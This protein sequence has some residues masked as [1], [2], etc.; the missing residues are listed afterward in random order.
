MKEELEKMEIDNS[1]MDDIL[2]TNPESVLDKVQE[3]FEPN[4]NEQRIIAELSSGNYDNLVKVLSLLNKEGNTDSICIKDSTVNQASNNCIILA[5][6]SSVLKNK[7]GEPVNLD[8]LNPK[9][10]LKLLEQFRSQD[11]IFIIDDP[12]NQRFI[13]TN[14]EV[15]LFLPKQDT[16]EDSKEI[17]IFDTDNAEGICETKID[18]DMRKIIKNLS[19]DQERIDLLIQDNELKAI[20]IPE[21]AIY[22]F[23]EFKKDPKAQN[24]DETNADISLRCSNF[25]PVEADNYEFFIMKSGEDNYVAVTDCKVGGVIAVRVQ[26]VLEMATGGN[27]I[28]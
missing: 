2:D 26:E 22:T 6:M 28:F 3:K 24:L 27:L 16:S 14:G 20:Y 17:E 5:D 21:T 8:I 18:K 12:E 15:K 19:K 10:Y 11:N 25:L 23:P 4:V 7:L 1:F 9:K 13:L